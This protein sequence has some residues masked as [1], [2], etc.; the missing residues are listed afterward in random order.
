ML[1]WKLYPSG[2]PVT[3]TTHAVQDMDA[4]RTLCGVKIAETDQWYWENWDDKNLEC[5]RCKRIREKKLE[6]QKN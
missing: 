4:E 1:A 5:K 2:F 3:S 6:K